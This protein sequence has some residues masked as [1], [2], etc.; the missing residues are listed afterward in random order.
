MSAFVKKTPA[1]GVLRNEFPWGCNSGILSICRGKS[2][3]ALIK[4]HRPL[5]SELP[6]I[7]V[8][9]CVFGGIFRARAA[10]QLAQAQFLCGKPPPAALPRIW[11]RINRVAQQPTVFDQIAPA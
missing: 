8:L 2:G 10:T 1:M 4:N 11:M 6:A 5:F 3:D 7:A 9:D